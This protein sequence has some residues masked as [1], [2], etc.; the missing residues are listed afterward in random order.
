MGIPNNQRE[1][2]PYNH[3]LSVEPISLTRLSCLAL[4]GELSTYPCRELMCQGNTQGHLP[5]SQGR[6][7]RGMWDGNMGKEGWEVGQWSE[8]KVNWLKKRE[9]ERK[10]V[11]CFAHQ[12]VLPPPEKQVNEKAVWALSPL[13]KELAP[14]TENWFIWDRSFWMKMWG[15]LVYSKNLGMCGACAVCF[16]LIFK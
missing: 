9:R 5:H 16:L 1:G 7:G 4:V 10:K 15:I 2:Y 14:E 13:F 8:C 11:Y 6:R 3:W 12:W